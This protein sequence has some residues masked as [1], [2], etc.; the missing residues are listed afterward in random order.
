MT[1]PERGHRE[2]STAEIL[3]EAKKQALEEAHRNGLQV[4]TV[5]GFHYGKAGGDGKSYDLLE[6][7]GSTAVIGY[8][9]ET[10][11]KARK[12]APLQDLLDVNRVRDIALEMRARTA[13]NFPPKM[14]N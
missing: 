10:D 9:N 14:L 13:N 7:K 3:V 8:E 4:G 12:E 1:N 6:I 2:M 5:V 11:G